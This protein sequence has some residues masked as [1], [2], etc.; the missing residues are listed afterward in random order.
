[1][2][3]LFIVGIDVDN[4]MPSTEIDQIIQDRGLF[5]IRYTTHSHGKSYTEVKK[6]EF[7]KWERQ[8]PGSTIAQYLVA[9]RHY[10]PEV[11]DTARI[12]AENMTSNGLVYRVEHAQMDK[13]R[14][15]FILAQ[16]WNVRDYDTQEEAL[17]EWKSAYTAFAA[18]LGI[19]I[20]E[21]CTDT[22]RLFY[23]PRYESG[24]PY[25]AVVHRGKAVDIFALAAQ[26]PRTNATSNPF[27][28]AASKMGARD[29]MTETMRKLRA[30]AGQGNADRFLIHDALLEHADH[31]LRPEMDKEDKHHI[32]CPFEDEHTNYGGSGTFI[33]NAGDTRGGGFVVKCMHA[34]CADRD[35]LDF[36]EGMVN[37]GW[38]PLTAIKDEQYLIA[39]VE[40]E[41]SSP[42][43]EP[44][45][46]PDMDS[47]S[48]PEEAEAYVVAIEA[49]GLTEVR[50]K[51]EIAA[52][53]KHVKENC[54]FKVNAGPLNKI[55]DNLRKQREKEAKR[56]EKEKERNA[57][58]KKALNEELERED[59]RPTLYADAD[60]L[61][62]CD[63]SM[64]ALK[65]FNDADPFIFR[66]AGQI[67]RIARD[68]F[69][70]E[71]SFAMDRNAMCSQMARVV[72]FMKVTEESERE[73]APPSAIIE[74]IL[75]RPEPP[76]PILMGIVNAPVYSAEG[77]LNLSPGYDPASKLYYSPQ[78]GFSLPTV[79]QKPT[80]EH[81]DEALDLLLGNALIDFPFDGPGDGVCEKTHALAMILQPFAR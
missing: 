77:V 9:K 78:D 43:A 70:M 69:D 12:A 59:D 31:I 61:R 33:M 68:E 46:I 35:R 39:V 49:A 40:E 5:C 38:L 55:F 2:E 14:L 26:T 27:L 21:S 7:V 17:R 41:D 48:S 56:L 16:P 19:Q 8:F 44:S 58:R 54:G 76:L 24:S 57:R 29:E 36:L 32:E 51:A 71:R 75:A 63:L 42:V 4:G 62:V 10:L 72:R 74:D 18:W 6:D 13:N 15:V 50:A 28:T 53:A 67:A 60:H 79:P 20:D 34:S 1:M 22:A 23:S 11:A 37:K 64:Q 25:E 66:F 3:E 80:K 81:V 65:A 30:W 73:I 52:L 47:V 45:D